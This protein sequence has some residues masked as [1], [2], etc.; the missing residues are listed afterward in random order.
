ME[1]MTVFSFTKIFTDTKLSELGTLSATTINTAVYELLNRGIFTDYFT[2]DSENISAGVNA[3]VDLSVYNESDSVLDVLKDLSKGHSAFYID[4][5]NKF[6]FK[7][8][9]PSTEKKPL[10][11]LLR[12]EN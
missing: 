8:V 1:N 2:V 9:E 11:I 4:I 5:D 7:A 3:T 12:K 6:Y 10:L